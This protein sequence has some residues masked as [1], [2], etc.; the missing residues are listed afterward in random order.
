MWAYK[1]D[2]KTL[3]SHFNNTEMTPCRSRGVFP[4]YIYVCEFLAAIY[5]MTLPPYGAWVCIALMSHSLYRIANF[6][7]FQ[8]PCPHCQTMKHKLLKDGKSFTCKSCKHNLGI[9]GEKLADLD[10]SAKEAKLHD[11]QSDVRHKN[12]QA[13]NANKTPS[14]QAVGVVSGLLFLGMLF[15]LFGG[16]VD[17]HANKMLDE[18]KTDVANEAVTQYGIADRNG[19]RIDKCV[20][21]G[22]VTAAYLQASDEINYARWKAVRDRDC[23]AAGIPPQ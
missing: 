22:L 17:W 3:P 18:I 9:Y 4:L 10:S 14:Q 20:Q 13:N 2:T 8:A 16:G 6:N 11:H 12:F 15:W 5:I 21:A 23:S 7:R 19:N 1:K